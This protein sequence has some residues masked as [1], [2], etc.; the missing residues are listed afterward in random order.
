MEERRDRSVDELLATLSDIISEAWTLPLSGDKC[1]VE[2]E[3][4]LDIIEEIRSNL[5]SDFKQARMI[6]QSRDELIQ[7]AK[8]ESDVIRQQAED[9]ARA[10]VNDN[11]I[12]M[13][14]R[15]KAAEIM[16]ETE[17]RTSELIA[18]TEK[19]AGETLSAAE[20][21]AA[22]IMHKTESRAKELKNTTVKFIDDAL[23]ETERVVTNS[24]DEIK[25][26]RHKYS[27][28]KY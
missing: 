2:R 17:R 23:Q 1:V 5:P 12:T 4:L 8:R 6:I 10:L 28:I 25:R 14:A 21:R 27:N 19:R 16:A 18:N 3:R 11:A 22:E 7:S 20:S 13:A 9:K 24:L 15:S 26:T